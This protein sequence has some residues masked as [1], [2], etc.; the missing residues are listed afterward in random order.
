MG[1]VTTFYIQPSLAV[2]SNVDAVKSIV[3]SLNSNN[4]GN[5]F[6]NKLKTGDIQL[7]SQLVNALSSS[8]N[9]MAALSSSNTGNS[10][11]PTI[12]DRASARE[13]MISAVH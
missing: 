6:V 12:D 9:S 8:L 10:T 7:T 13:A 1:A 5:Q 2:S 4:C 3:D 11:L